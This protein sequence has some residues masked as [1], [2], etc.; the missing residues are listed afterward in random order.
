[1]NT[2][3]AI[4]AGQATQAGRKPRNQDFHGLRLPEGTALQ[5]KGIAL[6]IADGIS[7]SDVAHIASETAVSSFLEDYYCTSD[8]W[9]VRNSAQRVITAINAWLYAQTRQSQYREDA[10]RGYVCTFSAVVFKAASAYLFHVGDARIYRLRDGA[11]E[12]LTEDHRIRMS[13]HESYLARAL[14]I[15]NQVEIDYQR[16]AIDVGDVFILATDGVYEYMDDATLI[17]TV[18]CHGDALETA[19][20]RI[21]DMAYE[22][23][24]HDNLTVQIV[25]VDSLDEQDPDDIAERLT[26]LAF[27]PALEPRMTFEGY[28]IVR[29]LH[30]SGR[31]HVFLARDNDSE[32]VVALKVPASD[33]KADPL[34][35]ERFLLEEW[36]ARRIDS[37]HVLKASPPRRKPAHVYVAMEY[38]EGQTLTQ[39]MIDHPQPDMASVRPIVEQIGKGVLAFHR[40]EMIHQDLRPDNILIDRL[41]TVKI[42][43]F[44]AVEVAG[45][46]ESAGRHGSDDVLGTSQY[47]APEYFIGGQ[48]TTRSDVYSLGVIAYQML[49]GR[50]PY[51]PNVSRARSSADLNRLN[52]PS[53]IAYNSDVPAWV[54]GALRKALH[55][56]PNQRYAEV[57]EFVYD[58]RHPRGGLVSDHRLPLIE[59]DPNRFW[60]G[61]SAVLGVV[62]AA[63]LFYI[64]RG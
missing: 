23:G 7:S 51:G 43:D 46:R 20:Q 1:M 26:D 10:D 45:I 56:N 5:S 54:D 61:L 28:E 55:P 35:L 37:P 13:R 15:N 6:A 63:L 59:R 22:H 3:L 34:L 25:R 21:V 47:A 33:L 48:G 24:S 12:R 49:T 64:A 32:Q 62:V 16:L 39:W 60:K 2:S 57:A 17:D 11:L 42:I 27:A 52:Y 41:G 18:A 9:S 8:A 53:A 50:L 40:Q 38:V 58:L 29:T 44:G 4:T 36:I 31:S 30:I 14:G 19:A